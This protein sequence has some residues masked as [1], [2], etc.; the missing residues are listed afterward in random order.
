MSEPLSNCDIRNVV[1]KS[2]RVDS[3]VHRLKLIVPIVVGWLVNTLL[4]VENVQVSNFTL[5][6]NP[7][8]GLL[9]GLLT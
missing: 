7:L 5:L 6:G 1:P 4:S 3:N 2:V 9:S 8:T